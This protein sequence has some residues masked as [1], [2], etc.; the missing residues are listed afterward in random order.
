ME[1]TRRR[2]VLIGLFTLLTLAAVVAVYEY[3]K[4]RNVF[5]NENRYYVYF[6]YVDGLYVS[7]RVLL[8]GMRIGLVSSI[9]FASDN[10]GRLIVE[11]RIPARHK[12]QHTAS[13][14]IVNTGLIGGR[15][16]R[17]NHAIGQGPYLQDGDTLRG[18]TDPSYAEMMETD[19]QPIIANADSLLRNLKVLTRSINQAI[20]PET[21]ALMQ[22]SLGNVHQ[23][24]VQ[25]RSAMDQL[26]SLLARANSTLQTAERSLND[27]GRTMRSVGDLADTM[28]ALHLQSV[29]RHLDSSAYTL[30]DILAR[31]AQGQGSLGKLLVEDSLYMQA[32]RTVQKLDSLV[33]DIRKQPKRYV[34]F[35]LF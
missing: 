25:L 13:A 3:M 7:N 8:N 16:V 5:R 18:D 1:G 33:L 31:V 28:R 10:S 32:Q 24:S 11:L 23:A 21:P 22:A 2:V 29:V 26:P 9:D 19:L 14:V 34:H 35:S 20:T 4:G 30:R 27:M 6:N 15:M 12:L 17:L